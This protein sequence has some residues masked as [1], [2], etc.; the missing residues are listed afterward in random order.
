MLFAIFASFV[1]TVGWNQKTPIINDK[2]KRE[3]CPSKK[4]EPAN[5][6]FDVFAWKMTDTIKQ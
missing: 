3:I 4:L 6:M 5:L 1:Q 2:V